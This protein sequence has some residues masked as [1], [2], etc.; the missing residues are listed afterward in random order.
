MERHGHPLQYAEDG[1]EKNHKSVR[2]SI[3][4]QNGHAR[5]RDTASQFVNN[6]L[7]GHNGDDLMNHYEVQILQAIINC[8]GQPGLLGSSNLKIVQF[9]SC[10]TKQGDTAKVD[11]FV[12]YHVDEDD[13]DKIGQIEKFVELSWK[14]NNHQMVILK[15]AKLVPTQTTFQHL[16]TEPLLEI[17][18]VSRVLQSVH[19]IHDCKGGKCT[20]KCN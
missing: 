14:G 2:S 17:T 5:S 1:F 10:V 6:E 3:A 15:K 20:I 16:T 13:T 4:H 8:G 12:L 9:K 7:M 19:V 18:P 11:S